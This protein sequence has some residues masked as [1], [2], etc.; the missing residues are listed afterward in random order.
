MTVS[1]GQRNAHTSLVKR[2]LAREFG[3]AYRTRGSVSTQGDGTTRVVSHDHRVEEVLTRGL[4]NARVE[5][6]SGPRDGLVFVRWTEAPR[7]AAE[8]STAAPAAPETCES[9]KAYPPGADIP[10]LRPQEVVVLL[11]HKGATYLLRVCT[12]CAGAFNLRRNLV[13]DQYPVG[14]LGRDIEIDSPS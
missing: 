5:R 1:I 8:A 10:C 6:G 3:N 13:L 2:V 12:S 4:P 14:E 7:P 9:S 11:G